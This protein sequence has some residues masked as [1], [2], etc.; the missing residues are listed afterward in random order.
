MLGIAAGV[1][2]K[3]WVGVE[4]GAG[5]VAGG[6]S[7]G[8]ICYGCGVTFVVG[9]LCSLVL[10]CCAQACHAHCPVKQDG[11]SGWMIFWSEVSRWGGIGW[12]WWCTVRVCGEGSFEDKSAIMERKYIILCTTCLRPVT[13][14]PFKVNIHG[15]IFLFHG[16]CTCFQ[17][18]EAKR[19]ALQASQ[20]E[21]WQLVLVLSMFPGWGVGVSGLEATEWHHGLSL[22][23]WATAH[24]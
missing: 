18:G 5:C 19:S 2:C 23:L 22:M 24:K 9:E 21:D 10:A 16:L 8:V 20:F 11:W 12:N 1:C 6:E 13:L 4:E 15:G 14:T 7:I 17:H 3:T